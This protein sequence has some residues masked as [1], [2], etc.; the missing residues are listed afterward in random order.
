[1][2]KFVFLKRDHDVQLVCRDA[3]MAVQS[4]KAGTIIENVLQ[5]FQAGLPISINQSEPK[6][7]GD[8]SAQFQDKANFL[9]KK[10]EGFNDE[11]VDVVE[12]FEHDLQSAVSSREEGNGE[13]GSSGVSEGIGEGRSQGVE[14]H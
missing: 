2:S 4:E 11:S 14:A 5:R 13:E 10:R 9:T 6:R 3:S 12:G 7:F 1:M 8:Y